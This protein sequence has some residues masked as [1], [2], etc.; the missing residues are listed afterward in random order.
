MSEFKILDNPQQSSFFN[1]LIY[2]T[3]EEKW[4]KEHDY[5]DEDTKRRFTKE[6]KK[7]SDVK[8]QAGYSKSRDCD[9]VSLVIVMC[10]IDPEGNFCGHDIKSTC[11]VKKDNQFQDSNE[12]EKMY[13]ASNGIDNTVVQ[14]SI[15]TVYHHFPDGKIMEYQLKESD[16]DTLKSYPN[17]LKNIYEAVTK[18]RGYYNLC[19]ELPE[20]QVPQKSNRIKI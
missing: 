3:E 14:C 15:M 16:S 17:E 6:L 7:H 1:E 11:V 13:D 12:Y 8:K 9:F 10:R 20:K 19:I 18:I 5:F 2:Q 4:D